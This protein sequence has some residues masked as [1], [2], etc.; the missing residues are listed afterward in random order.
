M[1]DCCISLVSAC[2][3]LRIVSFSWWGGMHLHWFWGQFRFRVS[4]QVT[5]LGWS[6]PSLHPSSVFCSGQFSPG[7]R[8]LSELFTEWE[9]L[10]LCTVLTMSTTALSNWSWRLRYRPLARVVGR[11][12]N[13][14][15]GS[16]TTTHRVKRCCGFAP[17]RGLQLLM[18]KGFGSTC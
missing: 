7:L 14:L 16:S 5:Q 4:Q 15:Q 3:T 6:S 13:V 2:I 9:L 18:N 17:C 12:A 10:A 8:K 1:C 11:L